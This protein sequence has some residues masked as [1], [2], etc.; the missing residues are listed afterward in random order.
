MGILGS[1]GSFETLFYQTLMFLFY[2]TKLSASV[3]KRR[4]HK[5]I[6]KDGILYKSVCIIS[7]FL[8]LY[9]IKISFINSLYHFGAYGDK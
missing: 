4:M 1:G 3:R 6:I 7:I 8:K 2:S 9:L 5:N